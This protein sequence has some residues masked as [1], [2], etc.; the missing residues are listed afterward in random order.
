MERANEAVFRGNCWL[1]LFF[2]LMALF[3]IVI[4]GNAFAGTIV[5]PKT[6]QTTSYA[7]GDDGDLEAG[8]AWPSPRFTDNNNGTVTDNLTGLVWLKN[9]NCTETVGGV[10]KSS[11]KLTWADALTWSNHLANGSCGLTDGSTA[12]DWRLPNMNEFESLANSDEANTATWLNGQGFSNVV[13]DD[14]Y[15]DDY[16]WSSTTIAYDTNYA[17]IFN[18][19]VAGMYYFTKGGN[20]YVWPVRSV[21][22]NL[23]ILKNGT[24]SGT[25]TS[26]PAKI[27]CE[28]T[29]SANFNENISV[30]LTATPDTGST[31]TGWSGDTDCSDGQVTMDADKTCTATFTL[32]QYTIATS[33]NPSAGGSVSCNP[34]PVDHGSTSTCTITTNQGYTLNNVTGTCGGTLVGST[35]TTNSITSNC[36]VEAN[37][38][39]VTSVIVPAAT[40][41]E[42]YNP[43]NKQS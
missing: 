10:N 13:N 6:G 3:F 4:V 36:T 37:F 32:N 31:F 29:C 35:Y 18:M 20:Y 7:T 21:F 41:N 38:N 23:V 15:Y 24:G 9:A 17:W 42:G 39:L 12:G 30:T 11:G 40:G 34:N 19:W 8:V 22:Y 28:G 2:L 5:L 16:Y 43:P 33:A 27:D 25:V 14:Y 26:A 1:F